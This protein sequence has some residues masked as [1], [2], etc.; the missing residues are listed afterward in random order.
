M[1]K[2]IG[3][4]K[5]LLVA[6]SNDKDILGVAQDGG[7]VSTLL[8]G[9]LNDGYS[10]ALVC[11]RNNNWRPSPFV[12]TTKQ[13]LLAAA[14]TSYVNPSMLQGLKTITDGRFAL[15]ATACQVKAL[16]HLQS[17]GDRAAQQI[18]MVIGLLC[19]ESYLY[20]SFVEEKLQQEMGI[21]PTK[22]KS[23]NIKG[24]LIISLQDGTAV[25]IPLKQL[26]PYTR[27]S[28][29]VCT[30]FTCEQADISVGSVGLN[31]YN[32]LITR[33]PAGQ[34]LVNTLL[35]EGLLVTSPLAEHSRAL[36]LLLTLS[37]KK[38]ANRG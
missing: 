28:C 13:D 9:C 38:K 32:F 4:H 27:K 14:G 20:H 22:I 23:M 6:R 7:S 36:K 17:R 11:S 10:G 25:E 31:G 12:A 18:Q 16:R 2:T 33:T 8:Q 15:V 3:P 1:I 5:G 24:K 30:D 37:A 34:S 35:S 19:S 26:R 29:G 21:E